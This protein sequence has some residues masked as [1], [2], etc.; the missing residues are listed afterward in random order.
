MKGTLLMLALA[1]IPLVGC[2]STNTT[3]P[4]AP[5]TER[6][7]RTSDD[8]VSHVE[9]LLKPY[10]G[11]RVL[12]TGTGF[13]I[14]IRGSVREPLYILDGLPLMPQPGGAL[15]GLNPNDISRIEVLTDP[16]DLTFYGGS[17]GGAGVVL[18]TTKRR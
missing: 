18:I 4:A 15:V 13:T 14:R 16:S 7:S 3:T 10:P 5:V 6:T 17:R 11:V 1:G 2:S 9:E 8:P 12:R